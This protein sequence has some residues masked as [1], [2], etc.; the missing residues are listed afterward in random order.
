MEYLRVSYSSMATFS[1]CPRKF[2]FNKLYPRRIRTGDTYAA[3]VGKSMHAGYQGYLT[4]GNREQAIWEFMQEFP[5]LEESSQPNDYRSFEACLRTL[6]DMFDEARMM[7]W[8]LAKI[9]RPL[10]ADEIKQGLTELPIVPAV[11][12]P[13]E[14]RFKGLTLPDGRG[15]SFIGFI[16]GIMRNLST[17]VYRTLDIKTSRQH[18][19]DA[20]GKYKFDGQQ[21]PYGVVVNHVA[22][23]AVEEFEVLYLDCYIDLLEPRVTFYPFK[24]SQLDVQEWALNKL[25]QFRQLQ[26]FMSQDY[27]PRTDTGCLSY[28]KPC[29]FLEPCQSRDKESLTE[30]FLMGEEAAKDRDSEFIPWIV[31]DVEVGDS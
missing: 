22:G 11:E 1:A 9:R 18:L 2:E 12:V 13:F 30:W 26:D 15:L 24:K 7:E 31:A 23:D 20:T 6:E 4:H 16:D 19:H 14:I 3:D 21:V 25:M 10:T 5:F 29:Y 8:E 27:F 17:G 28:N